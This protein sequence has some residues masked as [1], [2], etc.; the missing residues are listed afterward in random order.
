MDDQRALNGLAVDEL[1][2]KQYIAKEF[3]RE[4]CLLQLQSFCEIGVRQDP[5]INKDFA[6]PFLAFESS[7]IGRPVTLDEIESGQAASYEAEINAHWRI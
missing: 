6:E 1:L 5:Q 4:S 2:L 3:V 7:L